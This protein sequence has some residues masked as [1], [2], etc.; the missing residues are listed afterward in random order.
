ML[1]VVGLVGVVVNV[2]DSSGDVVG[3]VLYFVLFGCVMCICSWLV[4]KKFIIG[5][6]FIMLCVLI[7]VIC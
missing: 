3:D 2:L 6:K 7:C 4:L 5:V 1:G